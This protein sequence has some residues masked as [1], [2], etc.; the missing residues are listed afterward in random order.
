MGIDF[1]RLKASRSIKPLFAVC[2]LVVMLAGCS[3]LEAKPKEDLYGCSLRITLSSWSGWEQDYK[4]EESVYEFDVDGPGEIIVPPED[5][6]KFDITEI[7]ANGMIFQTES[8]MSP[9][10]G[11]INLASDQTVF[12][13]YR[14]QT[15]SLVTP[16]TDYGTVYIIELVDMYRIN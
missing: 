13:V 11:S 9:Y 7:N 4:P 6:F 16:S 14:G 3:A 10:G 5:G 12:T 15:L 1:K 8:S 2:L